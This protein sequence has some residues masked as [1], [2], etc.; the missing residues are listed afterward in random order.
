MSLDEDISAFRK[1]ILLSSLGLRSCSSITKCQGVQY[2][3][4]WR[5]RLTWFL[6]NK[7]VCPFWSSSH[8]WALYLETQIDFYTSCSY[9]GWRNL[10][11]KWR[12]YNLS[13]LRELHTQRHSVTT[14]TRECFTVTYPRYLCV[15]SHSRLTASQLIVPLF[16]CLRPDPIY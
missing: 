7:F 2:L 8:S 12:K 5:S 16:S 10:P 11:W 6:T 1:I 4:R 3:T 15:S 13:K 9:S 14:Q